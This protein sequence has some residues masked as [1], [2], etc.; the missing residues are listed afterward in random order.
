MVEPGETV[1]SDVHVRC[2][3]TT[4]TAGKGD[5]T[6]RTRFP[7]RVSRGRDENAECVDSD[8]IL[9]HHSLQTTL[10][11][12]GLQ[13]WNGCLLLADF[14]LTHPIL[15]QSR[16]E[17]WLELGAG[18]GLCSVVAALSCALVGGGLAPKQIV[19][20]DVGTEVLD[21]CRRNLKENASSLLRERSVRTK[22]RV[23]EVDFL[24]YDDHLRSVDV[25]DADADDYEGGVALLPLL[26]SAT[27][28]FAAD[29]IFDAD[30]TEGLFH[31]L[32]DVMTNDVDAALTI[33][34]KTL[35]LATEKRVVFTIYDDDADE[36][37]SSSPIYDHFAACLE[38]LLAMEFANG[39]F[40]AEKIDIDF[41]QCFY[42]NYER[43]DFL[44]LWSLSFEFE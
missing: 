4:T 16:D 38:G 9:V 35:Y 15:A 18:T 23:A 34:K 42:Q 27:T 21:L 6:L 31:L 33:P 20:T 28:I 29:V 25:Y 14:F 7:F 10:K 11:E 8:V 17:T 13:V 3:S 41:F 26:R 24:T 43:S 32:V 44:E 22:L 39:K 30:V 1:L 37:S 19:C 12:V 2:R 36:S 5:S 40:T